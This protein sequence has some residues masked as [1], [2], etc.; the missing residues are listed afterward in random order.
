MNRLLSVIL[1]FGLSLGLLAAPATAQEKAVPGTKQQV[2]L[3]FAP[4]VKQAVPAVV[5]IFTKRV[6]QQ[7]MPMFDDPFFRRFFGNPEALGL[8]RERVEQ[9]LGSGVLVRADGTV[10]TNHHVA[11][12]ASEI[13]V[14][15]SDRREFEAKVVGS[16]QRSD[17]AVLQLQGVKEKLPFLDLNSAGNVEVGDLVLAIGNPFGVGQTV[18][19]GIVSA[20][21]RSASNTADFSS[22][23]QTDAAINPGN[24]GG[25]LITSDG[26]LIGIN[27]QIISSNGGNIGIG[28]AIPSDM[29]R[30]V[31][32]SILKEGHAVRA[33]F[34]ATG[35][36]VTADLARNLG[37]SRPQGVAITRVAPSGPAARAG[38]KAGD[39]VVRVN[40]R[41]VNEDQELRY[42]I[43]SLPVGGT[44][45][46]EVLRDA[47]PVKLKVAL[48]APP[49]V[50]ARKTTT[51]TGRQP[52]AG[53]T[54]AN[55]N[56]AL[57][58]EL[59][60]EPPD[61]AWVI[62]LKVAANSIAARLGVQP[63]D[64]IWDINERPVKSV[65]QVTAALNEPVRGWDITI[66]RNGQ[67]LKM[68][69]PN[70]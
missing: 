42:T 30:T 62:V 61:E 20:L 28:L 41:E 56:P 48:Q 49:D 27:T 14:V 10:V 23:I 60:R 24:S 46:I 17:I 55:L 35:A 1:G 44:A 64:L 9:S 25:A 39:I 4:V 52:F 16:D 34:G 38:L 59:G 7:R 5:N 63:G 40:G 15:L 50:P 47:A 43:A 68:S 33:W 67:A 11:A 13:R 66:N 36:T 51:L 58:E 32:A 37:L 53:A 19:M 3:T 21:S 18:T 57:A 29:V 6:V 45:E 31:V 65:D 54:V 69:V 22:F 2:T 26:R 70:N 12:D 8:S